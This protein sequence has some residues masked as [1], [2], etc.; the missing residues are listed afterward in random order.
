MSLTPAQEHQ[1]IQTI[2]NNADPTIKT[3]LEALKE[4]IHA[5]IHEAMGTN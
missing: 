5:Q 3:E 1:Q 4:K 2:L